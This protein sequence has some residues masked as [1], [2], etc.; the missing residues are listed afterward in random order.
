MSSVPLSSALGWELERDKAAVSSGLDA[1]QTEAFVTERQ[2]VGDKD[3]FLVPSLEYCF[4]ASVISRGRI[5]ELRLVADGYCFFFKGNLVFV[6][7]CFFSLLFERKKNTKKKEENFT[8]MNPQQI[9]AI[10]N[11]SRSLLLFVRLR[12]C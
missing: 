12:Y 2:K 5:G 9:A 10:Q 11:S 7:T 3:A 6:E 4:R 1:F 8:E